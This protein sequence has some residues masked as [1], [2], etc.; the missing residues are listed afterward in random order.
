VPGKGRLTTLCVNSEAEN[1]EPQ[2][3]NKRGRLTTLRVSSEAENEEPQPQNKRGTIT[4]LE[5]FYKNEKTIITCNCALSFAFL[6]GPG[7]CKYRHPAA[8]FL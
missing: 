2:L 3:Q 7:V 4:I 6:S 1:G 8:C 5:G